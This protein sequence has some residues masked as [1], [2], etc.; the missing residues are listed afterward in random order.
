MRIVTGFLKTGDYSAKIPVT[1][2]NFVMGF[3]A[4][5]SAVLS[6]DPELTWDYFLAPTESVVTTGFIIP[7]YWGTPFVNGVPIEAGSTLFVSVS[8]SGTAGFFQIALLN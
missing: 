5:P 4:S 7:S 6:N 1:A 2:D 8:T 3:L